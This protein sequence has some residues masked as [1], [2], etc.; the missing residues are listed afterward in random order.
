[1]ETP[2][3]TEGT[4]WIRVL[5]LALRAAYAIGVLVYVGFYTEDFT[6]FQKLVVL[7]VAFIVYQAAKGIVHVARPGHRRSRYGWW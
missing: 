7:L 4:P 3:K 6:T 2:D 5:G 1:M